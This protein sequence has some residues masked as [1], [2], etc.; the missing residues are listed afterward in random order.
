MG[1]FGRGNNRP[2]KNS[3][4]GGG[5][6]RP[7]GKSPLTDGGVTLKGKTPQHQYS[8]VI[9]LINTGRLQKA[10]QLFQALDLTAKAEFAN[11]LLQANHAEGGELTPYGKDLYRHLW[12]QSTETFGQWDVSRRRFTPNQE[13]NQKFRGQ[14]ND[15]DDGPLILRGGT[16]G[17]KPGTVIPSTTSPDQNSPLRIRTTDSSQEPRRTRNDL[18]KSDLFRAIKGEGTEPLRTSEY[19]VDAIRNDGTMLVS[20]DSS[21]T[22]NTRNGHGNVANKTTLQLVE[23]YLRGIMAGKPEAFP[24]L[25]DIMSSE[26]NSQISQ[27]GKRRT[28]ISPTTHF[29]RP[30]DFANAIVAGL[31][32][33][34]VA[35][36][37]SRPATEIAR[38]NTLREDPAV[39]ERYGVGEEWT[40][41]QL[42][43]L[44]R[45]NDLQYTA[46]D[47][48]RAQADKLVNQLT[49]LAAEQYW[50]LE[51]YNGGRLSAK[52]P[53]KANLLSQGHIKQ[54]KQY[55]SRTENQSFFE[56]MNDPPEGIDRQATEER[57]P[58]SQEV[59]G[60]NVTPKPSERRLQTFTI[61]RDQDGNYY[62]DEGGGRKNPVK[63]DN[64]DNVRDYLKKNY[65]D[66]VIVDGYSSEHGH[67]LATAADTISGDETP[68]RGVTTRST[69]ELGNNVPGDTNEIDLRQNVKLM[70]LEQAR[71]AELDRLAQE[72]YAKRV[73]NQRY[74]TGTPQTGNNIPKEKRVVGDMRQHM[75][76]MIPPGHP[77]YMQHTKAYEDARKIDLDNAEKQALIDQAE[78]AR[79]AEEEEARAIRR[80]AL[81]GGGAGV[82]GIGALLLDHLS[83]NGD[84]NGASTGSQDIPPAGGA[85]GMGDAVDGMGLVH[86]NGAGRMSSEDRIRMYHEMNNRRFNELARGQTQ[87]PGSWN[88]E[89]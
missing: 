30:E 38:M 87:A 84:S 82:L 44:A 65:P 24:N 3:G 42:E 2:P 12:G 15:G 18:P 25:L 50:G 76:L 31:P 71:Q 41:S 52:S 63:S 9:D 23:G 60:P 13:Q 83:N 29:E 88:Y 33:D 37:E 66:A 8:V 74:Q 4:G 70:D 14:A 16:P 39:R 59:E 58:P 56:Y 61:L 20:E 77:D 43:K 48:V 64:P 32:A 21:R 80:M 45:D 79:L 72:E 27:E 73:A 10:T 40:Q 86:P 68:Q 47:N 46:T 49:R 6:T 1:Q 55:P 19:R 62:A 69:P 81:V 34:L 7:S 17:N 78:Q 89:R 22:N 54:M 67:S 28:T 85:G 5:T 75:G 57:L 35:Q 53:N 11:E 51:G 26:A 36:L